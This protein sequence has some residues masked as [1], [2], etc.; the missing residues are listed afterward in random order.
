MKP[1]LTYWFIK[2]KDIEILKFVSENSRSV[3]IDIVK[4]TKSSKK[5]YFKYG[6]YTPNYKHN[7][8]TIKKS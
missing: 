5:A 2:M 3:E 1:R 7:T 4:L 8:S 6:I